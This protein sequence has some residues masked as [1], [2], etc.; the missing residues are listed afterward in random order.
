MRN[1]LVQISLE[2]LSSLKN[3]AECSEIFKKERDE[4]KKK[5]EATGKELAAA[6]TNIDNLKKAVENLNAAIADDE[7][8]L[9][10][11]EQAGNAEKPIADALAYLSEH[12]T[13]FENEEAND[14]CSVIRALLAM[15]PK[16]DAPVNTSTPDDERPI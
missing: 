4:L 12:D 13:P 11:W 2:D 14:A 5:L 1:I 9:H 6:E 8:R 7:K 15:K 16:A 3:S 10:E